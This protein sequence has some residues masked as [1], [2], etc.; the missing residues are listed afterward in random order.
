MGQIQ[1]KNLYRHF[2]YNYWDRAYELNRAILND[3]N[4]EIRVETKSN[5]LYQ[6]GKLQGLYFDF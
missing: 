5:Q 1:L 4:G 2:L 6:F 3:F